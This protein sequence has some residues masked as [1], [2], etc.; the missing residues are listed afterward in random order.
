MTDITT[1][2]TLRMHATTNEKPERGNTNNVVA[3]ITQTS[4]HTKEKPTIST[5]SSETVNS[6]GDVS[7]LR[8]ITETN[9]DGS[10]PGITYGFASASVKGAFD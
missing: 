8:C 9:A 5:A 7:V 4:K 2:S 10:Q 6:E 1:T 3:A